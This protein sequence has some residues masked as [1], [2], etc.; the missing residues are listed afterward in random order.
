MSLYVLDTD[1][2]TLFQNGDPQVLQRVLSHSTAQL[3][4]TVISVEEELSGWYTRPRKVRKRDQLAAVY[5]RLAQAIPFSARFQILTFT[6]QAIIRYEQLRSTYRR[7]GKHDLQ[8][9]AI[10]LEQSA[11]LVTRNSRDFKQVA[12]LVIEDWSK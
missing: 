5:Q 9:A 7:L 3:A 12:G 2:V 4:T 11:I 8:I 6:E 1:I 10:A